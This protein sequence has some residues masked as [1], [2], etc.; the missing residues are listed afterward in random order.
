MLSETAQKLYA[1]QPTAYLGLHMV[2]LSIDSIGVFLSESAAAVLALGSFN[3]QM[4]GPA[5]STLGM[6]SL[7]SFYPRTTATEIVESVEKSAGDLRLLDGD[8]SWRPEYITAMWRH[9]CQ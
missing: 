3:H 4:Q 5:V 1:A 8:E 6:Q 7:I 9:Y 2:V